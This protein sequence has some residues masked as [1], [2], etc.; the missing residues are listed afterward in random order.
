MDLIRD[1][2]GSPM[3][4]EGLLIGLSIVMFLTILALVTGIIDWINDLGKDLP[5]V[6]LYAK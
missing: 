5:W 1:E 2:R 4:E 6:I 3:L